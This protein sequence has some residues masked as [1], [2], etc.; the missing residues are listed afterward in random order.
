M[1]G[2]GIDVVDYSRELDC[3]LGIYVKSRTRRRG[4][5]AENVFLYWPR[6]TEIGNSDP[7][8]EPSTWQKEPST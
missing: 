5:E 6:P 4:T 7:A 2:L 3:R 1:R 8:W